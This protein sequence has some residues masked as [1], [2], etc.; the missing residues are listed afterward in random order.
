MYNY[1]LS[2]LICSTFDR[3]KS[4]NKVLKDLKAIPNTVRKMEGTGEHYFWADISKDVQILSIIDNKQISVGEKRQRLLKLAQGEWIVFFDDDDEPYEYYSD[5]ILE[6]INNN[7]DID[8]IGINGV[9]TTN[10]ENPKTWVHRLGMQIRGNGKQLLTS[11]YHYERPIIH[12]NPVKREK[13][14]QAGFRDMRFGEDMDYASRL[15]PLLTKEYFI[16]KPL[17]H[18]RYTNQMPHNE[19]YGIK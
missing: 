8:C 9:M 14:I 2:I 12:F 13:A 1:K 18:Y 11:G 6:A 16:E 10:G 3:T 4:F 19:K 15:N 5:I 7:P 17:F